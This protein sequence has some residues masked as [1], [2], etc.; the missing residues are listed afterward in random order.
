MINRPQLHRNL[1]RQESC[2]LFSR[3]FYFSSGLTGSRMISQAIFTSSFK[4]IS[5][6]KSNCFNLKEAGNDNGM[7]VKQKSVFK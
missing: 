2:S 6:F 1:Y 4:N 7:T 5:C 3:F